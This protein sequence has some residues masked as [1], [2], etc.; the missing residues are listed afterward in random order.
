[1]GTIRMNLDTSLGIDLAEC[2]APDV[3][4]TIEDENPHPMLTSTAF[5]DGQTKQPCAYNDEIGFHSYLVP[6]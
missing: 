5:G 4:P 1:M 2:I 3:V 6:Y